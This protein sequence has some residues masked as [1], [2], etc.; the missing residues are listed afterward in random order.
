MLVPLFCCDWHFNA[1]ANILNRFFLY[2]DTINWMFDDIANN[3][4]VNECGIANMFSEKIETKRMFLES[5]HVCVCVDIVTLHKPEVMWIWKGISHP[6]CF[7]S[8]IWWGDTCVRRFI[9][10]W[11]LGLSFLD[12]LFF[13]WNFKLKICFQLDWK[14]EEEEKYCYWQ[15]GK[16]KG[17]FY[18]PH[19]LLWIT[20][21]I[22]LRT[23]QNQSLLVSSPLHLTYSM[24]THLIWKFAKIG[25]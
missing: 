8:N 18:V 14:E 9:M 5:V 24:T 22:R 20:D 25:K 23:Q 6:L 12:K 11:S 19:G 3:T 13:E 2:L 10:N 15:K 17:D 1:A 16:I 7:Q 21:S 4:R